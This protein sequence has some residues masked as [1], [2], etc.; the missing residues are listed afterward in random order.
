MNSYFVQYLY[1]D[2]DLIGEF[3]LWRLVGARRRS[4]SCERKL[5]QH[6]QHA[7]YL[8]AQQKC[9]AEATLGNVPGV[10]IDTNAKCDKARKRLDS[11]RKVLEEV[12]YEDPVGE[13]KDWGAQDIYDLANACTP[14]NMAWLLE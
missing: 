7:K 10:R 13:P 9:V 14:E 1:E 6:I 12:M 8:K 2:L 5:E 11:E 4:Y 3:Q